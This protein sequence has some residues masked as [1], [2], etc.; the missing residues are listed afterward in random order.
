MKL[1]LPHLSTLTFTF[2]FMLRLSDSITLL[3]L[4][5]GKSQLSFYH[6]LH[7]AGSHNFCSEADA[8]NQ[9]GKAREVVVL[10]RDSTWCCRSRGYWSWRL[11][12]LG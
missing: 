9:Q 2:R 8:A 1:N 11:S 6:P 4:L 10:I 12:D 3:S 5:L 7:N